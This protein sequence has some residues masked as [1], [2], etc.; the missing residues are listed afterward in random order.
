[1]ADRIRHLIDA[2]HLSRRFLEQDLFPCAA[3]MEDVAKRGGSRHLA[4]KRV[5]NLFYD[6]SARTRLSFESA[7]DLLGGSVRTESAARSTF[8]AEETLEDAVRVINDLRFSAIVL[9][10][11]QEGGAARAAVVSD[12]PVINAGDGPGQHPTQGLQ[13]LYTIA[14][15]RPV[16]G[17]R[18][19]FVGD[20]A[21]ARNVDALVYLLGLY[22]GTA[23]DFVSPLAFRPRREV[24]GYLDEHG[25][26]YTT[27]LSLDDVLPRA[28]VVY[29]ARAQSAR[30]A[31]GRRCEDVSRTYNLTA[32]KVARLSPHALVM[33]PGPRN[34]HA[35]LPAEVDADPR[36]IFR[37][38]TENGLYMRMALLTLLLPA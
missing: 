27:D 24:R 1:M 20:T 9:R 16:D 33:H 23:I 4:G 36:V 30:F 29:M 8:A 5:Y 17:L 15:R 26:P 28:D 32:E 13:D 38:Q 35:E 2:R 34:E 18:V 31:Y 10:Y 37:R 19:A 14:E 12:I 3:E 6:A 25:I 22:A 7:V 21:F 11:D